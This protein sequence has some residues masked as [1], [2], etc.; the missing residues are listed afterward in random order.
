MNPD[1][2]WGDSIYFTAP[3]GATIGSLGGTLNWL[4]AGGRYRVIRYGAEPS[5]YLYDRQNLAAGPYAGAIDGSTSID[6]GSYVGITPDGKYLVG[7][8]YTCS[9]RDMGM[10]TSWL[11]DHANRRVGAPARFWSLC[12]DR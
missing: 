2:T 1:A 10:G 9:P 5:L 11:I 4:D 3:G 6:A 8:D 7:Y 12:G